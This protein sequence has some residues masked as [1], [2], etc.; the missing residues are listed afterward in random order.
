M[1]ILDL[2]RSDGSI[3][4]NKKL[5]KK[6]GLNEAVI[7]SELI[8]R[9]KWHQE[10][11]NDQEGWFYCTKD[12]LEEQTSLNRYYQDK[13]IEEL[14]NLGLI[15]KITK[16]IPAKRY[17]KINENKVVSFVTGKIVKDSQTSMQES[18]KQ[19]SDIVARSNKEL[20]NT[21]NKKDSCSD[22]SQNDKVKFDENSKPYKAAMYLKKQINT[23]IPN[24]PTPKDSPKAME[25]WSLAMD[26][27]HRLGTVGGDSGYSW[28]KI[29]EIIDWCQQ[30]EFWYKN[31]LS[32]GKLRK[33]AVKLETRMKED[34]GYSPKQME[35]EIDYYADLRE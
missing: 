23:N 14:E 19:E 30:D 5:A 8:S 34:Q 20:N 1:N 25:E 28:K 15:S 9:F 6:I 2:L 21:N 7:L 10:E 22:K 11:G 29:R 27:L 26:R 12:T 4:V 32:A 13:A 17:F 33:Q 3:I 16:G 35:E 31:I 18:D 24:Q